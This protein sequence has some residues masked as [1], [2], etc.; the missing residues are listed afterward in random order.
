MFSLILWSILWL[1]FSNIS[2]TKDRVWPYFHVM[3]CFWLISFSYQEPFK[4]ITTLYLMCFFPQLIFSFC[5]ADDFLTSASYDTTIKV[6]SNKLTLI[7]LSSNI[8]KSRCISI[9]H[10]SYCNTICQAKEKL[11]II[12]LAVVRFNQLICTDGRRSGLMVSALDSELSC[13]G[14]SPGKGHCVVFFWQGT[15]LSKCRSLS[16]CINMYWWI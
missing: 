10:L 5:F 14:W 7:L 9:K 15:F 3:Q 4:A 8:V 6:R 11:V 2:N 16:R 12:D 1:S 13:A